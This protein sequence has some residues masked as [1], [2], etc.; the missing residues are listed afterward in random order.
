MLDAPWCSTRGGVA[1]VLVRGVDPAQF[2]VR[3][4]LPLRL[5]AAESVPEPD[6][7]V[8]SAGTYATEHPATAVLVIEVAD[9]SLFSDLHTKADVY[10][11]AGIPEL[12][13]IDVARVIA[14]IHREPAEGR[15]QEVVGEQ[16]ERRGDH[17]RPA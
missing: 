11:T 8:V 13:V 7:A 9:S 15:Y 16:A 6:A 3:V 1:E 12:W 17:R 10:A 14:S 4:Q 2:D 5:P